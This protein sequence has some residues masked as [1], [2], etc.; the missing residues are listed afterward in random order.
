MLARRR[1]NEQLAHNHCF[2]HSLSVRSCSRLLLVFVNCI[3][4]LLRDLSD[5]RRVCQQNWMTVTWQ[6]CALCIPS[7]IRAASHP[8]THT[9]KCIWGQWKDTKKHPF[10]WKSLL[11][12]LMH[13]H[14]VE[15]LFARTLTT[16]N[17]MTSTP[18]EFV[19]NKMAYRKVFRQPTQLHVY[20]HCGFAGRFAAQRIEMIA[21]VY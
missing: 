4:F 5:F 17:S 12:K 3:H 10:K 8:Q 20:K 2:V 11:R 18:Y 7:S 21:A 13:I 6:T 14:S 19:E 15:R 1:C 9:K 16:A